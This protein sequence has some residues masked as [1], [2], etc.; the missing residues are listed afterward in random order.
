MKKK[1]KIALL[2]ILLMFVALVFVS[3]WILY[4]DTDSKKQEKNF[5]NNEECPLLIP[6]DVF[7]KMNEGEEMR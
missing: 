6:P 2:I 4:A 7:W 1:E 3:F 5:C